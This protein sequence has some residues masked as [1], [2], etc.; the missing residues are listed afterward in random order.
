MCLDLLTSVLMKMREGLWGAGD[1][2]FNLSKLPGLAAKTGKTYVWWNHPPQVMG[3][4]DGP[5]CDRDYALYAMLVTPNHMRSLLIADRL[6]TLMELNIPFAHV[7]Q[8]HGH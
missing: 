6:P 1:E 5:G 3:T 4:R 8:G 2:P 7:W